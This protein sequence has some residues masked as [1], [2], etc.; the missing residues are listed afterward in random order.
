MK[1]RIVLSGIILFFSF[2]AAIHAG[3]DSGDDDCRRAVLAAAGALSAEDLSEEE[4]ERLEALLS[5]PLK[6]NAATR[7]RL[8][9]SGLFSQYQAAAVIDYRERHGDILSVA[10]LAAVDGFGEDAAVLLEPFLS[11]ESHALP[12][13]SSS[14]PSFVRNSFTVKSS[15]KMQDDTS[16]DGARPVPQ[17]SYGL[18]YR[19]DLNGSLEAGLACRSTYSASVFPPETMSFYAAFYGTG[20]LGKV[21]IGDFNARF[22][23]GLAMW[24]GFSLSGIPAQGA[25]SR[26]SSG[27]SPY[28]SYSGEGSHRGV[29][30]DFTVG[31]F[32]ISAFV[33]LPGSRERFSG[34]GQCGIHVLPGV[35]AVWTGM[36]GQVSL[37]CYASSRSL[38]AVSSGAGDEDM[39]RGKFM[40]ECMASAD[41]RYSVRGVELF[42]ETAADIM[43]GTAA[44]L[45]GCRFA[46]CDGLYLAAGLRYY[47]AGFSSG[48]SGAIRSGTACSNEYGAAVSG[49]F[50]FGRRVALAGRSGFGSEAA[51]HQG[52]FS[53]DLSHSPEPKYGADQPSS[54]FKAVLSYTCLVSGMLSMQWKISERLRTYGDRNRTDIRCDIGVSDGVLSSSVRFNALICKGIGLL[55]Y[56]EGGYRRGALYAY[57]KGGLFRVD[58]WPDRIYAYERDAPGNFSVPAYY[59]RGFWVSAVAGV[60]VSRWGKMYFRASYTGYPWL[61]PSQEKKKPGK[62]E[63]K[64]QMTFN[65]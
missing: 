11:F 35:N 55:T 6:I 61:S 9:E 21:I 58:N 22:G 5:R 48:Y 34:D 33:S 46:P 26:R 12:G 27:I 3:T 20:A 38:S 36:N 65:L 25:F 28:R 42:A 16:D 14:G 43:H 57:L 23:Q 54:Q 32:M 19:F 18:K 44:A 49:S 45:G 50:S 62:A 17:Y 53:I 30:A 10:E 7:S 8:V 39:S 64:V 63:L 40:S 13:R 52:S 2:Q 15:V 56:A 24:S 1:G 51:G 41:V 59:G 37:T 4:V 29:A 47:P 60:K 31:S